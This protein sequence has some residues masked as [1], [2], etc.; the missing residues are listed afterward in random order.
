MDWV[1]VL[2]V[3][4]VNIASGT[5]SIHGL[6]RGLLGSFTL[7]APM[8]SALVDDHRVFHGVTPVQP[9]DP[10]LP[11]HRDVLVLTFRRETAPM[12]GARAA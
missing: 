11:A 12:P 5:T 9:L 6:D 10:D 3:G 8:D 4:R 1:L 2:M 7:E